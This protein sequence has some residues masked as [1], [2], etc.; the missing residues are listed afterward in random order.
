MNSVQYMDVTEDSHR[1]SRSQDVRP[2]S[3]IG[4]EGVWSRVIHTAHSSAIL[5][6]RS[7]RSIS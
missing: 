7:Y 1:I 4:K 2:V 3:A 6:V 5:P